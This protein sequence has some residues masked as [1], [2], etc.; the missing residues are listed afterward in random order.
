MPPAEPTPQPE[1]RPE[2]AQAA[3]ADGRNAKNSPYGMPWQ[4]SR[5]DVGGVIGGLV[6][7]IFRGFELIIM[8][9]LLPVRAISMGLGQGVVFLLS[10]P[11][12]LIGLVMQLAGY[13]LMM[14]VLV[15][16]LMGLFYLLRMFF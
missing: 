10:L 1:P 4:S 8:L 16:I 12:R 5:N 9:V 14:G 6:H 2:A 15:A 7:L 11:F 3:P 13:I